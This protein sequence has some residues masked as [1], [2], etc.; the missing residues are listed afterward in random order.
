MEIKVGEFYKTRCGEKAEIVYA[1]KNN[2]N[3]YPFLAVLHKNSGTQYEITVTNDG[4]YITGKTDP[5]DLIAPW[6]KKVKVEWWLNVDA[7]GAS[8][9]FGDREIA[10]ICASEDRIACVKIDMEVEEGEGL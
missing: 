7:D 8:S 10:N 1:F 5:D 2:T 3:D 6:P 9:F 4:L